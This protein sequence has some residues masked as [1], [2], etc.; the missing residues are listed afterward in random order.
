MLRPCSSDI[1]DGL[2]LA[3]QYGGRGA[4]LVPAATANYIAADFW[5]NSPDGADSD[6]NWAHVHKDELKYLYA[7]NSKLKSFILV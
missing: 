4:T 7:Y 6:Y 3:R 1:D 5:Y 2:S